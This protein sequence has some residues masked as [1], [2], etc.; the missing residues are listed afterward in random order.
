MIGNKDEVVFTFNPFSKCSSY[1][2]EVMDTI[3]IFARLNYTDKMLCTPLISAYFP[4][5]G[6]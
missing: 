2:I 3:F 6:L 4:F 5:S 1:S